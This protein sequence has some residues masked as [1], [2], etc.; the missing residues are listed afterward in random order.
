[1]QA[2]RVILTHFSQRYQKI[3]SLSARGTRSLKLEDAEDVDNP[4]AGMD[5]PEQMVDRPGEYQ[6]PVNDSSDGSAKRVPHH[7]A[8]ERSQQP[9]PQRQNVEGIASKTNALA[10][11]IAS[12]INPTS[13]P[14]R[15]DVRIGVAFDHMRIKVG[16]IMHLEKF[17]PALLELYKETETDA[18]AAKEAF[19]DH[20]DEVGPSMGR[21]LVGTSAMDAERAEK[22]RKGR[23]KAAKKENTEK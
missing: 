10:Q 16:E 19:S 9:Q 17:T 5:D 6:A 22:A 21:G 20:E 8:G 11:I 14:Q 4:M 2:R 13:R 18:K 7:D 3:P 23:T 12:N 1:M 15:N